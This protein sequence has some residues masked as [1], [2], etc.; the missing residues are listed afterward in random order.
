MCLGGNNVDSSNDMD[1]INECLTPLTG[2]RYLRPREA[3]EVSYI[4]AT[5][6]ISRLHNLL[7]GR[8]PVPGENL[9][10]LFE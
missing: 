6:S 10:Q 2:R 5:D 4:S 7:V 3:H 8:Q 9:V 1:V